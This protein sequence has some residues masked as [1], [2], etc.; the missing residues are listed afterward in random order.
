MYLQN[1][2]NRMNIQSGDFVLITGNMIKLLTKIKR[3]HHE[4]NIDTLIH[5]LLNTV[6]TNGTLA[7]QTFNWDFCNNKDYHILKSKSQ[8]GALG[9]T[10]LKRNDFLRTKHP[11]YSFAIAGHLQQQLVG[12]NNKGA[13]DNNSPF[14]LMHEHNAKMIIIDLPLQNSFTFVHYVEEALGVDYRYN[15]TFTGRY[16]DTCGTETI[17]EYDVFVRDRE[18]NVQTL[19]EPLEHIFETKQAMTT[20]SYDN[21]TIKTINLKKAYDI[22]AD[23]IVNNGAQNLHRKGE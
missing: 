5:Q 9:N 14:K 8:T 23:D 15:K 2:I 18:H 20:T 19:V 11:V 21:I 16:T 10:A 13:F 1:F 17:R 7:I 3:L 6:D 4:H 22:I 12:L